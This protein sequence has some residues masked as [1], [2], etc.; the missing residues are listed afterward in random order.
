MLLPPLKV[1]GA[2]LAIA[3]YSLVPLADAAESR[4]VL[5][6][7]HRGASGLAPEHTIAAYDLALKLG[8]DYIEQDLQMT[9][10]GVLVVMHDPTLDRTAQ[11]PEES[12]TGP[13]ASKTLEQVRSCDVGSWFNEEYPRRSRARY[14][15]LRIPTLQQVFERYGRSV[16]YYIETKNPELGPR[17][18]EELLRMLD[19]YRLT[20]PAERHR[21]VLIQSFQ[22]ESLMRIHAQAPEL[23][24]I[25]LLPS[26]ITGDFEFD[27]IANYA[28]GVGPS[29]GSVDRPFVENAHERGLDIHPYTVDAASEMRRLI[30]IEVDGM[31]TNRPDRLASIL[32]RD[33]RSR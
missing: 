28:V 22:P 33:G 31:F 3:L 5:N 19:E 12:C 21:R 11:G 25:Q 17:M 15:G 10:D 30:D 2:S 14:E 1:A 8:A 32:G 27:A 16:N 26:A 4:R 20:G 6:V 13:V 18:E 24:L 29:S 7:G 9:S 23:P